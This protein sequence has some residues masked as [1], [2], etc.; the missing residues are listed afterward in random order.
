MD[1]YEIRVSGHID[2]RR[3]RALGCGELSLLAC[4]D[5]LLVFAAVDQAALYGLL[6]RLRDAG[7]EL[8]A[9]ARVAHG[10]R[11]AG[12]GTLPTERTQED[13]DVTEG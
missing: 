7:L 13:A 10:P 11:A 12:C 1:R 6:A 4:G 2:L 3:A 9:T 8:V 5:S